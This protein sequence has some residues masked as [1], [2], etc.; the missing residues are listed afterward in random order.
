MA[1]VYISE[2]ADVRG[3]AAYEPSTA[4][5]KL[6]SA[7]TS[8]QSAAFDANTNWVR[9]H[10]DGVVSIKFGTNPTATTGSLRLAAGQTE[11]FCIVPGHKVAII[12]NT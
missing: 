6:T 8:S 3:N 4:L 2:Y 12:D 11:Y 7:A 1:S 5:Q 10:T 9:V